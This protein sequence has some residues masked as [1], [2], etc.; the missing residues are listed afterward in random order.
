M[1]GSE[2][3]PEL[4]P[5]HNKYSETDRSTRGTRWTEARGTY[6]VGMYSSEMCN[7]GDERGHYDGLERDTQ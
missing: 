6:F 4:S 7:R 1:I 3:I 5:K 2:N